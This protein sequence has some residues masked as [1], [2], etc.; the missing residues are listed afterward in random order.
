MGHIAGQGTG[1]QSR[2]WLLGNRSRCRSSPYSQRET[3]PLW[4]SS[5]CG[6]GLRTQN[7]NRIYWILC[8]RGSLNS[9]KKFRLTNRKSDF[10]SRISLVCWLFYPI[11]RT[12]QSRP[13]TRLRSSSGSFVRSASTMNQ[14]WLSAGRGQLD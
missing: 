13:P 11:R 12:F 10:F 4:K 9:L 2:H 8:G 14:C 3:I 7:F 1:C 5:P 6:H